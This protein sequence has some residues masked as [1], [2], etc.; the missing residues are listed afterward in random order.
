MFPYYRASLSLTVAVA[1]QQRVVEL[2]C[3]ADTGTPGAKAGVALRAAHEVAGCSPCD[4]PPQSDPRGVLD[5]QGLGRYGEGGHLGIPEGCMMCPLLHFAHDWVVYREMQL[6]TVSLPIVVALLP[7]FT[8]LFITQ[9]RKAGGPGKFFDVNSVQALVA[10]GNCH[11]HAPSI[12]WYI[13]IAV[14]ITNY[15]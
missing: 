7:G 15:Y 10:R 5:C 12:V 1:P 2:G 13:L 8:Q 6:A 14:H 11:T 9:Y 3:C 4:V